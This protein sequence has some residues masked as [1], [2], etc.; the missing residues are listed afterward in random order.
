MSIVSGRLSGAAS[1]L[2]IAVP[3]ARKLSAKGI[4]MTADNAIA[5]DQRPDAA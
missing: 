4:A 3:L 5:N 1:M 2:Y